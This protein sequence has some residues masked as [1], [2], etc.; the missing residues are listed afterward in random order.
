MVDHPGEI[1]L[2]SP[3]GIH[4]DTCRNARGAAGDNILYPVFIVNDTQSVR[5]HAVFAAHMC[6]ILFL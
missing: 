5:T 1:G 6:E 2:D 3:C 4:A